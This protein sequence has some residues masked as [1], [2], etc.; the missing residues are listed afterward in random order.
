MQTVVLEPSL[1]TCEPESGAPLRHRAVTSHSVEVTNAPTHSRRAQTNLTGMDGGNARV[2]TA[3]LTSLSHLTADTTQDISQATSRATNQDIHLLNRTTEATILTA[4]DDEML[5]TM[6]KRRKKVREDTTVPHLIQLLLTQNHLIHPLPT[7][8]HPTRPLPTHQATHSL[9]ILELL[10]PATISITRR[11]T[12]PH[13][14]SPTPSQVHTDTAT[15]LI[16]TDKLTAIS[17]AIQVLYHLLAI[18]SLPATQPHGLRGVRTSTRRS[19]F[20]EK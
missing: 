11:I 17:L 2:L 6:A 13:Q 8:N 10:T 7:L 18:L 16:F 5:S 20:L 9:H 12:T 1:A 14:K 15:T 3:I 4:E 19:V